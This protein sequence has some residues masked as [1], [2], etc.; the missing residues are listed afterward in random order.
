MDRRTVSADSHIIEPP[1]LWVK[2][3]DARYRDRAPRIVSEPGGDVFICEDR[4]PD[5]IG[6]FVTP[7]FRKEPF[8]QRF[9]EGQR[10]GWDPDA[11][12]DDM[13]VDGIEAEVLY[14]NLAMRLYGLQDQGLQAACFRAYNDW[15][16]EYCA[17]HP[18]RLYGVALISLYDIEGAVAELARANEMGLI[19]A[20]IWADPPEQ[21][22]FLDQRQDAFWA[23][24]QDR[25]IPVSLHTF[26][27]R[28]REMNDVFLARY[29][30]VTQR[31]QE[32]IADIIFSR[33]LERFPRL[34][35]VSAENDVG[36]VAYL[37]QRMDYGYL[38]KGPRHF[39]RFESG[40][41]PSEQFRRNVACTFMQ[42]A[43]GMRTLGFVGS[44]VLMWASDYPHDDSTWPESQRIIDEMFQ[45][46]ADEDRRKIVY[47]NA[48]DLYRM[49]L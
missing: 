3:I 43:V 17:A 19:G 40:L 10:G 1:D 5:R 14:P 27:G 21:M 46:I 39:E 34:R 7:F 12:I 15:L 9:E 45:G 2:R 25:Q 26:T 22:T 42:D 33:V 23:E 31:V 8:A 41:L 49:D 37:L 28:N 38:R 6:T 29:T 18:K 36:W 44:E 47:S 11:R 24:A 4:K 13:A 20:A 35:L 30:C 16:A 48:V 32:S